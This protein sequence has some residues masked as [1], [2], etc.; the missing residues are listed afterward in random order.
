MSVRIVTCIQE[1]IGNSILIVRLDGHPVARV[2]EDRPGQW[3]VLP[4]EDPKPRP[5]YPSLTDIV[6]ALIAEH[7]TR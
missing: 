7:I 3:V 5:S 4:L 6:D 2:L 1:K